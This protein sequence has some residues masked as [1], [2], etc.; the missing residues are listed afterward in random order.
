MRSRRVSLFYDQLGSSAVE[1]ALVLPLLLVLIFGLIDAGRFIWTANKAEKATQMGVRFA[2]ATNPVPG[3]LAAHN[4][5]TGNNI[6]QGNTIPESA[7][8]GAT[9]TSTAGTAQS[10]AVACSC[11]P[12]K[13]C[14]DLGTASVTAFNNILT[15]MQQYMPE[16]GANQIE[17]NYAYS[18]LG[19]AGDPNGMDVAPLVRIGLRQDTNRPN[20]KPITLLVFDASIPLPAFTATLTMEDGSGTVSN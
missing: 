5:S 15:R 12:G 19:Y 18:G 17:V 20:F 10:T 7:F 11:N 13:T 3:G 14:P 8:G 1:F 9:C 6:P 4:F 2:V 16:L